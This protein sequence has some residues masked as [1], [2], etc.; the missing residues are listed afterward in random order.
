MWTRLVDPAG[1]GARPV[2][3]MQR[4][5]RPTRQTVLPAWN[6]CLDCVHLKAGLGLALSQMLLLHAGCV[7]G[8]VCMIVCADLCPG[9]CVLLAV[10]MGTGCIYRAD[11]LTCTMCTSDSPSICCLRIWPTQ[12]ANRQRVCVSVSVCVL[13]LCLCD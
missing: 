7:F 3:C 9:V 13:V 12:A 11:V 8:F 1:A 2:C 6:A 10:D 5:E 4:Q